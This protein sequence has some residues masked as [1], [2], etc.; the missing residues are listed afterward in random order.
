MT[1]RMVNSPMVHHT[2]VLEYHVTQRLHVVVFPNVE[3]K[4]YTFSS[5]KLNQ[6]LSLITPFAFKASHFAMFK[7][8]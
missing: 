3:K 6:N 8:S 7:V 1:F 5:W 4:I 2:W